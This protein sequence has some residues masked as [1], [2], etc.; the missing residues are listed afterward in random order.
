MI[1]IWEFC[2][3][4]KYFCSV[5]KL[6]LTLW[7]PPMNCSTPG[8][9]VLHYLPEFAQTHV[10]WVGDAIQPSHPLSSPSP[11][12]NLSQ[13]QDLFQWVSFSTSDGQCIGASALALVLPTNVHWKD[14]F[15]LGLTG[16]IS[17]YIVTPLSYIHVDTE[18]QQIVWP[19]PVLA[20]RNRY[21]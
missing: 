18:H 14:W 19:G 6:C 8:F 10:H 16:L 11:A 5:T 3:S 21:Y 13:H 1:S 15:P 2:S 4:L 9:S 17:Y 12:F 20:T 7:D